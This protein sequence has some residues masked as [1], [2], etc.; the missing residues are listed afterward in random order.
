MHLTIVS[1]LRDV[2]ITCSVFNFRIKL[3]AGA[4]RTSMITQVIP[5]QFVRSEITPATIPPILQ[6]D[7]LDFA[8]TDNDTVD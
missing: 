4:A 2:F 6:K 8:Q 1:F 5:L 7:R 3:T